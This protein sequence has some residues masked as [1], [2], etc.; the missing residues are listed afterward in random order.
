LLLSI[1]YLTAGGIN[2]IGLENGIIKVSKFF[3]EGKKLSQSAKIV[4]RRQIKPLIK[5][6]MEPKGFRKMNDD[7]ETCKRNP[8]RKFRANGNGKP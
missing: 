3:V 2:A 5:P 1:L 4:S 7:L 8:V 6:K